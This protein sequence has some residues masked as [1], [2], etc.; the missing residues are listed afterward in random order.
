MIETL[1]IAAAMYVVKPGDT[2]YAISPGH[3]WRPVCAENHIR[4]CNLIYP[5][6]R[7]RVNGVS[8][9]VKVDPKRDHDGDFDHDWS[10]QTPSR[11]AS[12]R[13]TGHRVTSGVSLGGLL[14]CG[15]L[16]SLWIAAGGNPGSAFIAAEIAMAESG[17][18]QY[19]LSPTNDYG[20]WQINGSHGSLATFNAFGNARAA[21]IISGN[22]SNWGAW[23][24]YRTGAYIGRC[25]G[26]IGLPH[27]RSFGSGGNP[28]T[29]TSPV[30]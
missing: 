10:D 2:L 1:A 22:G 14:G 9:S 12:N 19:A 18:N 25:L 15:G 11:W 16:E 23:T 3:N 8:L 29:A 13:H 7:L 21:I 26:A 20:Y 5:G 4:N 30:L 6:Q 27:I 24:T 17:G 28:H